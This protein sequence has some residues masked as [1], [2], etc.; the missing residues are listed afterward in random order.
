MK[1]QAAFLQASPSYLLSQPDNGT[2][3]VHTDTR[4]LVVTRLTGSPTDLYIVRHSDMTSIDR[5]SY[6]LRV[7]SS[8]GNLIL[9]QMGGRLSLN[10]R[11]SKFHVVD[12]DVGGINLIYSTA[13][14]FTW[15]KSSERITLVLYGGEHEL[16][17]FALPIEFGAH[18]HVE[19]KGVEVHLTKSAIV[20]QWYVQP[21]RRVITFGDGL[22]IHL[23]WRNEAY[24]YWVLD[25]PIPG[26]LGLYSS[27]SRADKSVIVKGGYLLRNA[28]I[29]GQILR[30]N[31]DINSTTEIEVIS[32][33]T[34]IT[35][36]EFN[37][38][39]IKTSLRSHRTVG[40]VDYDPPSLN[41]PDLESLEWRYIDSLPELDAFF[42]DRDWTPCKQA[43]T[44]N[45][46]NLSTPTSLYAGDYG[47]H[48]GSLL[49]RGSFIADG[50]ESFI[51][52]LT[53]GGYAYGHSVW[54]NST[55][56]GSWS[57]TDA[58]MFHNQTLAFPEE[59]KANCPYV[60]TILIDHMGLDLNFVTNVQTMKDPR[61]IM[62]FEWSRDKSDISWKMT[63]NLGGEKYH[64][65]S[66]GPLNEGAL[67]V[68]RQGLHL[69]GAP[70]HNWKKKSPLDGISKPGVGFFVAQ[71]GLN[72]PQGYD[73]PMSVVFTNS[74]K[75]ASSTPYT[76]RSQLFVNGWQFGK[77]GM[78]DII[79]FCRIFFC[80]SSQ[81]TV[82]HI[83]PQIR[84][85][86]PEG[87][88]NYNGINT[89]AISIWS[90]DAGSVKLDGI[91]LESDAVLLSGY[92]KPSF[93]EAEG[94]R[95]RDM[96]N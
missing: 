72:I 16:H 94:Y 7:S 59:L 90:M 12:Y 32:A 43:S 95:E 27:P 78:F 34:R 31:G 3:G 96:A 80:S 47:Y 64:D 68:E 69:P 26:T 54:L 44:H 38:R 2:S 76:F 29:S 67:Y 28:S 85:P 6:R 5:I 39:A 20:V 23:L 45:T 81:I 89:I 82:N 75:Q 86:V 1:L 13:E 73:V 35:G 48:T 83:G 15:K 9:P 33:P 79:Y 58:E 49:Y 21:G 70:I 22:E 87:I 53:E 41:L 8:I 42:D 40:I 4:A 10:G 25:L 65:I 18:R 50:S 56:L 51:Y 88:L 84:F 52:L 61:G 92:V 19:G 57:G 11:D 55:Y 77:Y 60:L 91:H 71:F 93:V 62:D 30:L 24:N 17:E 36:L 37:G 46:R 66:R 14:I 74:T 63:G